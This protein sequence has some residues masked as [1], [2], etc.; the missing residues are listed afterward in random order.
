MSERKP[1]IFAELFPDFV[2]RTCSLENDFDEQNKFFE[3]AIAWL[4]HQEL[5]C[6][7]DNAAQ[8]RAKAIYIFAKME[9]NKKSI[10]YQLTPSFGTFLQ[11]KVQFNQVYVTPAFTGD[12]Q[13]YC[14][15]FPESVLFCDDEEKVFWKSTIVV[16][17]VDEK[18]NSLKMG[19]LFPDYDVDYQLTGVFSV[20]T[21]NYDYDLDVATNIDLCIESY[22]DDYL[23]HQVI[24][25]SLKSLF[26]IE[27]LN[28]D[29]QVEKQGRGRHTIAHVGRNLEKVIQQKGGSP[30]VYQWVKDVD[31]GMPGY[32]LELQ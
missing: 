13:S 16:I 6:P 7:E 18:A 11:D 20:V 29:M 28:P 2:K 32:R 25:F 15:E 31:R 21:F 24:E 14:I 12:V 17:F 30:H 23:S 27:S 5:E 19:L 1:R 3:S 9:D 8:H 22:C 26:Y 10:T 4:G